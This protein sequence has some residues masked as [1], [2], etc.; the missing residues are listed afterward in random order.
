[1]DRKVSKSSLKDFRDFQ[2][3][4]EK[5]EPEISDHLRMILKD[6]LKKK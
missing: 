1:L 2:K 5:I 4:S 6:E 3:I